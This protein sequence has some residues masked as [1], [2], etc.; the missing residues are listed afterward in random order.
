MQVSQSPPIDNVSKLLIVLVL[1]FSTSSIL[2][3][4]FPMCSA[5]IGCHS[6]AVTSRAVRTRNCPMWLAH[7]S[8]LDRA[9]KEVSFCAGPPPFICN[10][11]YF[12]LG[13]SEA[14]FS[15]LGEV[16][17]LSGSSVTAGARRLVFC[18]LLIK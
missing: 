10:S 4:S 3:S 13:C 15:I 6:S 7:S 1:I 17:K 18:T 11:V 8:S 12:L 2:S 9:Q 14:N 5:K 16:Y